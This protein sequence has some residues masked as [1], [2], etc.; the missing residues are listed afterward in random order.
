MKTSAILRRGRGKA[1]R[2]AHGSAIEAGARAGFVA[3]G[4]IYFLVG[5][6]ALRI[7]FHDGGGSGDRAG[8]AG[9]ADRGGALSEMAQKPFGSVLLWATGVALV[10]MAVWRL[11][12][13]AFG[14]A[15]PDGRKVTTRAASGARAVFYGFVSLSVLSFAAG[16]GG[17]GS[18]AGDRQSQD[19]TARVLDLPMGRWI[20]GVAGAVVVGA[21]LWTAGQAVL[22]KYHK[23]LRMSE[24]SERMRRAVD[25]TGVFGGTARGIVFATAGG[26]LVAAA[27]SHEPGK[28]KGMDDTLRSLAETPVG[29]WLLAVIAAGLAAFGLFSCACGRWHRT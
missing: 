1:R 26:F 13:A 4:V 16:I 2:A 3:R 25:V 7:A 11:S 29:P 22:R 15:G 5:M 9:Q 10:G 20:T 18:G 12:E 28:A 8:G 6:L 27:V 19:I 14:A 17:S 23:D 21:G 24:M